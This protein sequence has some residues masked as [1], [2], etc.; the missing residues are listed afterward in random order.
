MT[1]QEKEGWYLIGLKDEK[2]TRGWVSQEDAG[3]FRPY[4]N[5]IADS[6]TYLTKEWDGSIWKIPGIKSKSESLINLSTRH[7]R[8]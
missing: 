1:Y 3:E 4:E 8:I 6:L 2:L 5:L 7:V